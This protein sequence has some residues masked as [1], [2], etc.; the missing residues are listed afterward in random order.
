ME[1]YRFDLEKDEVIQVLV[2]ELEDFETAEKICR[3]LEKLSS[4]EK[5]KKRMKQIEGIKKARENGVALGRPTLQVPDNFEQL[6]E[7]WEAGRLKA[8]TA[9]KACGIG[10]STFYRRARNYRTGKWKIMPENR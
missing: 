8:G 9:A 10:I 5:Q 4:Q 3:V 1:R 6:L 7:E 2:K